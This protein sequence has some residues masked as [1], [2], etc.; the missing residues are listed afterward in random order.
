MSAGS[1]DD[2]FGVLTAVCMVEFVKFHHQFFQSAVGFECC[3]VVSV[4][5][6]FFLHGDI[7]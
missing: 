7:V 5:I 3:L 6:G 2:F 1:I 4:S